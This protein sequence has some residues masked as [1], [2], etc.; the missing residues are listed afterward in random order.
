MKRTTYDVKSASR[1]KRINIQLIFFFQ[2][3]LELLYQNLTLLVKHLDEIFQ[4][5]KMKSWR[6]HFSSRKPFSS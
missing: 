2:G 6:Q 3:L 5:F 1:D 4:N